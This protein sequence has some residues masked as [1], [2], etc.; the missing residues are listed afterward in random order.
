MAAKII[1]NPYARR[2]Q[3]KKKW[4]L[5][6]EALKRAGIEYGLEITKERGHASEIAAVAARQGYSPIVA[7]GGEGTI[8]EIV[9]GLAQQAPADGGFP[10][11]PLGVIP[12]GT[13]NDLALALGVPKEV[14]PAVRK[15]AEGTSRLIDL[16]RVNDRYFCVNSAI[17]IEAVGSYYQHKI[18]RVSGP[19]RYLLASIPCIAKNPAWDLSL[20]WDGGQYSGKGSLVTVG[21]AA[22]TAGYYVTPGAQIDDGELTFVYGL[23][24]GRLK[25]IRVFQQ[26]RNPG[27]GNYTEVDGI[28]QFNTKS[29]RVKV[30][31]STPLH[32]DGELISL[33]INEIQFQVVP[34]ALHVIC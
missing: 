27:A 15:I 8:H 24:F 5:V 14:G 23:T 34:R 7:A 22:Q 29:L 19:I 18:K 31:P 10:L 1:L 12:L 13:S 32:A 28:N 26:A 20:T 25:L 4:P 33:A 30:D 6:E 16:G 2:S 9:N 21:N 11:G 17:G 3:A